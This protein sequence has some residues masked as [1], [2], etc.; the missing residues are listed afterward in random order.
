MKYNENQVEENPPRLWSVM[1]EEKAPCEGTLSAREKTH[2]AKE[3]SMP[4]PREAIVAAG[5]EVLL[6]SILYFGSDPSRRAIDWSDPSEPGPVFRS[7]DGR[8][9]AVGRW[10]QDPMA[11]QTKFGTVSIE[12]LLA[13][14]MPEA[15]L[16]KREARGLPIEFWE[17]IEE[18]HDEPACWRATGRKGLTSL[19]R[20]VVSS[21][22]SVLLSAEQRE[23]F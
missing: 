5:L 23:V 1:L 9:C 7:K 12:E 15:K 11:V 21:A 3:V 14:G 19:G 2:S 17:H 16:F 13:H 4:I 18:L 6:D 10:L 22:V 8:V 20:Q